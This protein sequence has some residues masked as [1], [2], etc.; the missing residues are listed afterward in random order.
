MQD[1]LP[2]WRLQVQTKAAL[3]AVHIAKSRL[4]LRACRHPRARLRAESWRGLDLEDVCPHIRQDHG[5]KTPG[6]DACKLQDNRTCQGSC[7]RCLLTLAVLWVAHAVR[8]TYS[9]WPAD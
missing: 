4:T 1:S 5:T 8:S 3:I 9:L 2:L 6:R 7:H